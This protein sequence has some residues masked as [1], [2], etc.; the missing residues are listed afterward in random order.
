MKWRSGMYNIQYS[1]ILVSFSSG[2]NF[3]STQISKLAY[4]PVK[5]LVFAEHSFYETHISFS[6][7]DKGV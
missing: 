3:V 2:M 4:N 5:E 7:I 6:I 1:L